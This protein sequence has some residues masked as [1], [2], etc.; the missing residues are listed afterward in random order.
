MSP[1][2]PPEFARTYAAMYGK[3]GE[4][5]VRELPALLDWCAARWSLTLLPREHELSFNFVTPAL[6]ADGTSAILK[7]GFPNA[8]LLSEIE[9]LRVYAGR[10]INRLL[11]AAPERGA[12]LLER[13]QPGRMLVE[14]AVEDDERATAVAAEV[15]RALWRPAPAQHRF[16]NVSDWI[17][18][19]VKLR[20]TF[21][22]GTGPFPERLVTQAERLFDELLASAPPPVLL[23]GD[24]HHY[25][26]LTAQRRPWL[27]I[28][29]KGVIGEPAYETGAL[30]RNPFP[31]AAGWPD[32]RHLLA[33][34]VDLLAERLE[35]DRQRILGWGAA[36][37]VLAGWWSY[38]DTGSGW[39]EWLPFAEALSALLD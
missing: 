34:R 20:P 35:L 30:L 25:N 19:M 7:V 28:D 15:M 24:L 16:P 6:R 11:E 10:G 12:L 1:L 22:G 8:E 21:G 3:A 39:A 4:R 13:L 38:E 36:Q 14:L 17:G 33:R 18:G 26:I 9:A 23:H 32:L 27:A 2:V 5:W 37:C 29:P 31:T